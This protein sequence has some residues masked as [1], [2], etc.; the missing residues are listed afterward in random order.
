MFVINNLAIL[1]NLA[2]KGLVAISTSFGKLYQDFLRGDK[3]DVTLHFKDFNLQ[4]FCDYDQGCFFENKAG[5]VFYNFHIFKKFEEPK[6]EHYKVLEKHKIQK[7]EIYSRKLPIEEFKDYPNVYKMM[8]PFKR[9]E[10]LFLL[11]FE[12]GQRI[13]ITFHPFMMGLEVLFTNRYISQFLEE[14]GHLYLLEKEIK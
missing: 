9:T 14:Y 13:L 4:F 3:I 6:Y 5:D 11:Y 7:I 1:Q 10:D 12:D 2:G 8:K